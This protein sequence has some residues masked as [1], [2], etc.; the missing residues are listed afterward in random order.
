MRLRNSGDSTSE[1]VKQIPRDCP[2]LVANMRAG[3]SDVQV[4]ALALR[5]F[6]QWNEECET[7]DHGLNF[8]K[9]ENSSAFPE[10]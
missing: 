9:L 4:G 2:Q 10:S 1:R 6:G 7:P 8:E 5:L 3:G